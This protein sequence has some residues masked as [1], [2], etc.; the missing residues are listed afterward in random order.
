MSGTVASHAASCGCKVCVDPR[1]MRVFTDACNS[2]PDFLATTSR[3]ITMIET[4]EAQVADGRVPPVV[5]VR[6]LVACLGAPVHVETV[7]GP[8]GRALIRSAGGATHGLVFPTPVIV[9]P[10]PRL[11]LQ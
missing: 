11:T 9:W 1:D 7:I 6:V 5:P 3:C 10:P 8:D 4:I 2:D